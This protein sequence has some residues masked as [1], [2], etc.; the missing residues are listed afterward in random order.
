MLGALDD[1]DGLGNIRNGHAVCGLYEM[2]MSSF[3]QRLSIVGI[4]P[5]HTTKA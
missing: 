5:S 3:E 2:A 4:S 1:L